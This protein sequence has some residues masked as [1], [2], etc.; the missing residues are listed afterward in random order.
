M[1]NAAQSAPV[2]AGARF[3]YARVAKI[4]LYKQMLAVS[5]SPPRHPHAVTSVSG[6][7][8]QGAATYN[9]DV[10]GSLIERERA[11]VAPVLF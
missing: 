6:G 7:A 8:S 1:G 3:G 10:N 9:Y 11:N 4:V 5:F 2:R